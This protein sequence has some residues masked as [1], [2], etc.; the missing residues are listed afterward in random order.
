MQT[1]QKIKSSY[2][3]GKQEVDQPSQNVPAASNFA[4][5][6]EISAAYYTLK[7]SLNKSSLS[8]NLP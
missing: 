6:Y 8:F 3:N 7:S 5:F 2:W 1:S 4:A